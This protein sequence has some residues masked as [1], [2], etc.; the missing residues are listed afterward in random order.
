MMKWVKRIFAIGCIFAAG[1]EVGAFKESERDPL[2]NIDVRQIGGQPVAAPQEKAAAVARLAGQ[3]PGVRVEFDEVIGAPKVVRAVD[4]FL[5]GAGAKGRGLPATAGFGNDPQR[6]TKGFLNEHRGLF[7]H[8]AEALDRAR[9]KREFVTAHNGMLTTVWQQELDGISVHEGILISHQT[10][11]EELVN[12]SSQFVADMVKSANA[13]APNRAALVL[14]P[15]IRAEDA[16]ARAA[17]NIGEQ[18]SLDKVKSVGTREGAERRQQFRAPQ[19]SGDTQARLVWLPMKEQLMRLCWEIILTSG[20]R[21]EMFRLLVD[22]QTGEV[23][24]RHCLTEYISDASYRVYTSDSPSPFS[25]GHSTPLTNQ[26]PLVERSL[27]TLAALSTNASPN[28]WIND[29]ENQTLGNNVHAHLDRNADDIPDPGSRPQGSPLRVFDFPIDLQQEPVTYTNAAVVQLFYW[30]N[31]M[32]DK[33]YD[34]GFTEAAGNFQTANFGRGGLGNDPVQADAQDGS[35]SNN[36]NMA[37]PPDGLSPRMQMFRFTGPTPDR[38]GDLDAEIIL[39][40]YTHG[41]SNRRVGGG[42]GISALQTR[43]MGEG[44]SDFYALALLSESGDFINGNYAVGG[45][46]THLMGV[47]YL[48][49]YYFG[50]RRYPY[51]TE[52]TKNPLTFK[53]IDPGQASSHAGIPRNPNIGSTAESVHN[54]GEVWCVA[55]WD[56]RASLISKHGFPVGNELILQL[57]TDGMNLSPANPNF[58]QARDAILLADRVNNDGANQNELWAAFAKRGMGVFATSPASSTTVGVRESFAIPDT[59]VIHPLSGFIAV[60]PVGGPYVP[61]AQITTLSNAGPNTLNWEI[62]KSAGWLD[63]SQT[64]GTL[65]AG[66]AVQVVL[67]LNSSANLLPMGI[68]T[69]SVF[70]TNMT[71]GLVQTQ[72]VVA[73]TGMPDHFTELFTGDHD[74]DNQ[75]LTFTPDGSV[76]FYLACREPAQGFSTDPTSGTAV[77]VNNHSFLQVTLPTGTNVAIY[78]IRTNIFFIGSGGFISFNSGDGSAAESLATHFNRPRISAFMAHLHPHDGGIVTWQMLADRIAVTFQNVLEYETSNL[79]NFQTEMF[80]DGRIRITHLNMGST[81]GLTGLSA[82]TGVPANFIESN[83]SRFGQCLA[84]LLLVVPNSVMEG[85]GILAGQGMVGLSAPEATDV[86]VTLNSSDASEITVPATVIIFAG[87][88]NAFFDITVVNDADLDGTQHATITA[89]AVG[90]GAAARTISVFDDEIGTLGVL[91]PATAVEGSGSITGQ[92]TVHVA[93]TVNVAVALQSSDTGELIVP[94]TV[95]IPA[96]ATSVVFSCTVVD[97]T[98]IDGAQVVTVTAQV[99]NWNAGSAQIIIFDNESTNLTLVLPLQASEGDG[100][101][102]N[103]GLARIAG[104]LTANLSVS[105]LSSDTSDVIVPPTITIPAGSTSAVFNITIVDDD[106]FEE[107][108]T[109]SITASASGFASAVSQMTIHDN[110]RPAIPTN[111]TPANMATNVIA[112]ADLS[113]SSGEPIARTNLYHVYLGTT[114][115]LDATNYLGS[116]MNTSW[117]LPML[118]PQTTYYWQVVAERVT[119]TEGPVWQFTTRGVSYFEWNSIASPQVVAKPFEITITAKDE[120]GRTVSNYSGSVA[121]R[122]HAGSSSDQV[123]RILSFTNYADLVTEY[124]NTLAAIKSHFSQFVVTNT[125]TTNANTLSNLLSDKHVFLI[126]EQETAFNNPT[127]LGQLGTSW[128]PVLSNFVNKGGTVIVCSH[129]QNE[130]LILNNSGLA[131]LGKVDFIST[132]VVSVASSHPLTV[133]VPESFQALYFSRYS[134]SNAT[135]VLRSGTNNLGVVLARDIGAGHAVMIG[136]DYNATNTP[137]DRVIANAVKWAQSGIDTSISMSPAVSGNFSNGVWTGMVAVHE[138]KMNVYLRAS[139]NFEY[140]GNSAPFDMA[141]TNDLA[142]V[143]TSSPQIVGKNFT[144]SYNILVVNTGPAASSGVILTNVL[145]DEAMFDSATTT[146]GVITHAGSTIVCALGDMPGGSDATITVTATFPSTGVFTNWAFISRDEPEADLLNNSGSAMTTVVIPALSI[147]DVAVIEGDQASTEARFEI[148]LSAPTGQAVTVDFATANDTALAGADYV[149]TN[150]TITFAP[151]ETNQNIS[152]WVLGDSFNEENETFFVHLTSAVNAAI[153]RGSGVGTIINDDFGPALRLSGAILIQEFCLPTNGMVDPGE[154]VTVAITLTNDEN[155]A[156]ATGVYATLLNT[157]GIVPETIGQNYGTIPAGASVTRPFSFTAA[158]DCGESV[159]AMLQLSSTTMDFGIVNHSIQLCGSSSGLNEN[160]DAVSPPTVPA[161]W[162]TFRSGA[163]TNWSTTSA[164]RDSLP[165]SIF[166]PNPSVPSDNQLTSPSITIAST[167]AQLT[168][169]HSFNTELHFD[170]GWLEIS[171]NEGVFTNII[172]AGG[173]FIAGSYNGFNKWTGNSGGFMTSV[174]RLP[175]SAAGQSVRLQ[176]RFVSDV[177]NGG[178]GWYVDTISLLNER[179]C[180]PGISLGLQVTRVDDRLQIAWFAPM[181]YIL[182]TTDSLTPAVW[183]AVTN[184]VVITNGT[185]VVSEPI[186]DDSKFYRLRK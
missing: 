79:N 111:P 166:A 26:P 59:L 10:R 9:I 23:L 126:P 37:T 132:G 102:S 77:T 5:S 90:Y 86:A 149:A 134:S 105:L 121:L 52:M 130:H 67:A 100:T 66:A 143:M 170:G 99:P 175:A 151:G 155:A 104:T 13:G 137:M 88:T 42:V 72:Q 38:D 114:S 44:W 56:A 147:N 12:L 21:G 119:Q 165:N 135:T 32:H 53:D 55:L 153:V 101:L 68:Y 3:L 161:G 84:P 177:S 91:L 125:S 139:D 163:G 180:L 31:W 164:A 80:Y 58:L 74:L 33:L 41:L 22:A 25:P 124:P 110:E 136:T 54:Q 181:S 87:A 152:V 117:N 141:S 144:V 179:V 127:I 103:A 150:G 35:G 43:G 160:F 19:L 120:F 47:G 145:P 171:I 76:N 156:I 18:L 172:A 2:P 162:L 82:G 128:K 71:S 57:V 8:G 183:S 96:G 17:E 107:Q 118:D 30:N 133:N 116:T 65:T 60:G 154:M 36:A 148:H 95:T 16:V 142:L 20:S 64:D 75:M 122:A 63:V 89:S 7:G 85:D 112:T 186:A 27:V 131:Q 178:T 182:E 61:D 70:F 174:V 45:Y 69:N 113:W 39:H 78:G 94:A 108:E 98:K 158:G 40:E 48:Q 6:A 1:Q 49:N 157:N 184:E 34:L 169:R 92:I 11:H 123:V 159:I 176:W 185:V 106:V 29:G 83:L 168:F 62:K 24:L 14:D 50:I 146:Q 28:G 173:S 138:S 51:S 81:S 97:D 15:T 4:G 109:V 167:N 93:P 115:N 46:L 129:Q 73:R 140:V